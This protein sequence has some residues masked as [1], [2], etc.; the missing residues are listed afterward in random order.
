MTLL[1]L[2]LLIQ[3]LVFNQAISTT[4][5][6]VAHR[7]AKKATSKR[8]YRPSPAPSTP[9][10]QPKSAPIL[11]LPGRQS[12]KQ[13]KSRGFAERPLRRDQRMVTQRLLYRGRFTLLV[14]RKILEFHCHVTHKSTHR[15]IP[16]LLYVKVLTARA[17]KAN[18]TI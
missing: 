18:Q 7:C 9:M 15:T 3:L 8:K 12:A 13:S 1:C 17:L 5:N 6:K 14:P 4:T 16:K 2:E 11:Q 10:G